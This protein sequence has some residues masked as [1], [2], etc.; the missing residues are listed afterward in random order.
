M[1]SN[2]TFT[3]WLQSYLTN[4]NASVDVSNSLFP[5]DSG[6]QVQCEDRFCSGSLMKTGTGSPQGVV[7]A[8]VG[9][10]Y[11]RRD[12]GTNTTLYVKQS[13]T[14]DGLVFVGI[15]PITARLG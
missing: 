3:Q 6:P 15:A 12:G 1:I 4:G 5:S 10:V 13:G 7:T 9:S 2:C 11:M 8:P 14:G